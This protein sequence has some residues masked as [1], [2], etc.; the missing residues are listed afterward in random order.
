V[1]RLNIAAILDG[2]DDMRRCEETIESLAPVVLR[3]V[4]STLEMCLKAPAMVASKSSLRELVNET[5]YSNF[6][7]AREHLAESAT[8]LNDLFAPFLYSYNSAIRDIGSSKVRQ[9]LLPLHVKYLELSEEIASTWLTFIFMVKSVLGVD[10]D[11]LLQ[12]RGGI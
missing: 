9:F 5:V 8:H 11:S 1:V 6:R 2:M 4:R 3:Q 7:L 12:G 10:L